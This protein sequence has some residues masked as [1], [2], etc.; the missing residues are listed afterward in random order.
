M[1]IY[2]DYTL[3]MQPGSVMETVRI[4][5][6]EALWRVL[7]FRLFEGGNIFTIPEGSTAY[8]NGRKADGHG[9]SYSMTVD[10]ANMQVSIPVKAQMSAAAGPVRCEVSV[11][12]GADVIGSVNFIMMVEP[13]PLNGADLSDSDM[14]AVV[15]AAQNIGLALEAKDLAQY[16][17]EQA[18]HTVTGVI[19]F[20]NR[21]GHVLPAASDYSADMVDY[22]NETVKDALDDLIA[23]VAQNASDI[24]SLGTLKAPLASPALTGTPTAPT[25]SGSTDESTLIATTKFVWNAIRAFKGLFDTALSSSST[26]AVQNKVIKAALDGKAATGHAH[27][28]A[29]QAAAGFMSANDK[30]YVDEMRARTYDRFGPATNYAEL[31]DNTKC[32]IFLRR[33]AY[34][35]VAFTVKFTTQANAVPANTSI[36]EGLPKAYQISPRF[37]ISNPSGS[38]VATCYITSGGKMQNSTTLAA[39]TTYY[40][41]ITYCCNDAGD[42]YD[43][44]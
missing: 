28:T 29:T 31:G 27:S 3:N 19:D 23:D 33:G 34:C 41:N 25:V 13:S 30:K 24:A 40:G 16:Y 1:A 9:F 39:N 26:N 38:S 11:Q 37:V 17:A 36:V 2:S 14:E 7:R 5:Q 8:L 21:D 4:S 43:F 35:M 6:G 15:E 20:N 42:W 18:E 32:I 44:L 10:N 22:G 12:N